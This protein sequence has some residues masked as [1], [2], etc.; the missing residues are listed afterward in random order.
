VPIYQGMIIGLNNRGEDMDINVA[1]QK[2]MTN[3][4]S[5]NADIAVGL[6]P[7]T[8]LSLEQ[9]LDFIGDDELL[10]VTPQNL[11]LRKR[12]LSKNERVRTNRTAAY[13]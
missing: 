5:E 2:K 6:E 12:Y 10:E 8:I 4:R 3:V 1:K 9:S 11:R 13:K 7:P